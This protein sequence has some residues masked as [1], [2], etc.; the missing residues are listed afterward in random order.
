MICK[1]LINTAW[2]GKEKIMAYK[3]ETGLPSVTEVLRPFLNVDWFTTEAAERG[4]AVH[5]ACHCH[6]IGA[7][8]VSLPAD[9]QGY[10]T[11]FKKWCDV[12][13][14]EAV[15]TEKRLICE[16]YHFCGQP[17]FIGKVSLCDG[18]GLIDFKTSLLFERWHRLQ[19]AGYRHLATC[20]G[21]VTEWGAMLRLRREG[22]LA[23]MDYLPSNYLI[24]FNR[25]IMAL[26]LHVFF[27]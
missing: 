13:Q 7:M 23:K 27:K 21:I 11:S 12:A 9:W 20:N 22:T 18:T 10:F 3:N 15:L 6:L 5:E 4:S 24:D 19:G 26:G 25:F 2:R 17:D 16:T 14:P 8:P 1:A